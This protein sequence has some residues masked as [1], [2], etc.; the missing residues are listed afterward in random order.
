MLVPCYSKYSTLLL[1][2]EAVLEKLYSLYLYL[3]TG[4]SESTEAKIPDM[5]KLTKLV[6]VL[7]LTFFL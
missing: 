6:I 4:S 2:P 7:Y 3:Y 5:L 1:G